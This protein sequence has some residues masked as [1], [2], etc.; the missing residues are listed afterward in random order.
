MQSPFADPKMLSVLICVYLSLPLSALIC[1]KKGS[2][3]KWHYVTE[4]EGLSPFRNCL[5]WHSQVWYNTL[6]GEMSERLKEHDWKSC[7]RA[8]T[9]SEGSNPSLSAS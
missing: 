6:S 9:R 5:E 4:T 7:E 8:K 1:G 2:S 3:R